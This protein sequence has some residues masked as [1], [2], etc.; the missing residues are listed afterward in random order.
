[1]KPCPLHVS[2]CLSGLLRH[3]RVLFLSLAGL[4]TSGCSIFGDDKDPQLEPTELVKFEETLGVKKVWSQKLGGGSEALR[5]AL[6]PSY[7]GNRIYA[8]SYDGNVS[9]L[10]PETGKPMWRTELEITLSA[11]PGIDGDAVA[12]A[13]YDGE[14][15]LL[16]ATDGSEIWRVNI[17]GESLAKPVISNDLVIV[18]TNDGRLRAY[19]VLDG[20]E[21]W[22]SEQSLPAL[23]LRGASSPVV[24]GSTVITGF[25]NG[26]VV[27]ATVNEGD[28]IWESTL[29]PPSG[30]S[31]L[32]RL[33]DVDGSLAVVGQDVYAAGYQGRVA[34]LAVESGQLLWSRELS[35]Y[36]GVAADWENVYLTDDQGELIALLRRNGTDVWRSSLLLRR[37]P[38]VPTAFHTAVVV[39]DFEGYVHFFANT[40]GTMVARERVG[41]GAISGVPVVAGNR[42]LVQSESGTLSAFTVPQPP[43][44]GDAPEIAAEP[45][46]QTD[47]ADD[48]S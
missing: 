43:Q 41:K 6:S 23:T 12:V 7:D 29:T 28:Q 24:V 4:L 44:S 35:G 13:G 26:R 10:D 37:E 8:A 45:D 27:A 14:L 22:Q 34:A 25:D 19:S 39:G 20:S 1:M 33:A 21:R 30:R 36:A 31:D 42:L 3:R 17:T 38:T 2:R 32:E 48:E 46:E 5:V 9:A 18:Y 47:P 15:V 40:D 11:G 16:D